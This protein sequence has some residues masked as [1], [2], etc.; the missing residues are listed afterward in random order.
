MSLGGLNADTLRILQ[1]TD[2]H[3]FGDPK[4]DLL[5]ICSWDSLQAVIQSVQKD[6]Q[7]FD[8]V[9]V[10]GDISQDDSPA[11]YQAFA[12]AVRVFERPVVWLPG[13]HDDSLIMPELLGQAPLSSA[14][15]VL[16]DH[17]Q[18]LMLDSQVRGFT[19]GELAQE[20]LQSVQLSLEEHP[21]LFTLVFVHHNPVP[22]GSTWLD[23][24]RMKNGEALLSLLA[25]HPNARGVVWGHVHQDWEQ[26]REHLHLIA[27]PSTCIQ[28]KPRSHQ[29]ALDK[30][31]PGYRY[32]T[33][34]GNGELVTELK[35]LPDNAFVPDL[36][37]QGY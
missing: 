16:T 30:R 26:Q 29:F 28:F 14:N 22:V 27:T 11:S 8:L 13:N 32:L 18:L 31:P 6:K 9:V 24:H 10:T 23:Q 17:W 7:P 20:Q 19:F 25:E 2:T 33:L 35:R 36:R 1:I 3:L 21:E 5:G 4:Q 15:R 37:A 34:N 12:Q